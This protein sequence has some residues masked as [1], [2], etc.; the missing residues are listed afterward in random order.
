[1]I[2]TRLRAKLPQHLSHPIGGQRIS[3]GLAGAPHVDALSISFRDMALWPASRFSQ[4][5]REQ[6]PYP[7]LVARFWPSEKP[8]YIGS[9]SML[10]A[11]YYAE[12]WEIVV[13]PVLR[14]H[15][16]VAH[17]LLVGKGL[18]DVARWL[19]SSSR[20]GWNMQCRRIELVFDPVDA[21]LDGRQIDGSA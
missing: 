3:D 4:V 10:D 18:P 1:M 16:R 12:R 5:L 15:R 20:P 7:I 21:S 2:P 13:Y 17:Q 19:A 9:R 11:G 6:V 14:E 8:G